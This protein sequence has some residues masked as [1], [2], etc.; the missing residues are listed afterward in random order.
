MLEVED[1]ARQAPKHDT[2]LP[3]N[4]QTSDASAPLIAHI[5]FR[6]GTGG[7]ENGLINLINHMP[8]GRYRH[9]IVCLKGCDAFSERIRIPGVAIV[10]LHKGEGNDIGAY[11]RAWRVLR[12][13][14]PRIVHLR[15]L[16]TI[17]FAWVARLAGV[18]RVIQGEHGWDTL[19]L[20]GKRR[21]YRWLRRAC[22]PC[23][24]RYITVS[25]D[26]EN[27]LRRAIGIPPARITRIC[28]G[29]DTQS[30]YPRSPQGGHSGFRPKPAEALVIGWV[31]RMA[32]VKAPLNLVEAFVRLTRRRAGDRLRLVMV[33]DG[34]LMPQVR[35]KLV[36]AGL[37]DLILLPG[38]Q[39]NV[40]EWL[41]VMDVFVLPSLNEGISN[42]VLEA[43]AT[44]LPVVA[45]DVGGNSELI[46]H[47]KTGM[48]VAPNDVEALC[49]ALQSY[50]D[51]PR[52]VGAH[53]VAAR[54]KA[55]QQFSLQAMVDA[56]VRVYDELLGAV[57]G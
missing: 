4:G 54:A 16:G 22:R 23:V 50:I 7:L 9:A 47:G 11:L 45:T 38:K 44:G 49:G 57:S 56:Y 17:D 37:S 14:R 28:N 39:E 26:L 12:R 10:D 19:D 24:S 30:F 53:G 25:R 41:R 40:A 15:N 1:A 32:E 48:L 33:G 46:E 34:P 31:G 52:L 6:L 51:D 36:E 35:A 29:V 13:L 2:T 8:R 27:W 42:T 21:K 18:S 3:E 43:M 20:Y 55:E 5:I